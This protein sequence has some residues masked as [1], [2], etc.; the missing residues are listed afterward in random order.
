MRNPE[1]SRQYIEGRAVYPVTETAKAKILVSREPRT[2]CDASETELLY[3][4]V[5]TDHVVINRMQA[6]RDQYHAV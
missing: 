5:E 3:P 1:I 4:G 2:R 6:D